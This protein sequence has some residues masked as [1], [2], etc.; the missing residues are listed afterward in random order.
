MDLPATGA[1][2]MS[3][4]VTL[5]RVHFPPPMP[6]SETVRPGGRGGPRRDP[7]AGVLQTISGGPVR[8]QGGTQSSRHRHLRGKN[9]DEPPQQLQDGKALATSHPVTSSAKALSFVRSARCH[10]PIIFPV[11]LQSV[12][13][14]RQ[15]VGDG[16][17]GTIEFWG[18]NKRKSHSSRPSGDACGTWN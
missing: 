4:K 15:M 1:S 8:A 10:R 6:G 5:G 14:V 7:G 9:Q 2:T 11:P 3:S 12:Q 13:Q 18:E 17:G 16:S